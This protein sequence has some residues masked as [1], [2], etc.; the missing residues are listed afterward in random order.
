MADNMPPTILTLPL[1]LSLKV[2][3]LLPRKDQLNFSVVS[4]AARQLTIGSIFGRFN[5]RYRTDLL[6]ELTKASMEIRAAIR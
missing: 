5:L 2:V 3:A 4:H 6:E 1:E